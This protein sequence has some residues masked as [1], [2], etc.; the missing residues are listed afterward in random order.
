MLSKLTLVVERF[1][2][3]ES[4]QLRNLPDVM[5]TDGDSIRVGQ[6]DITLNGTKYIVSIGTEV[7]A[8]FDNKSIAVCFAKGYPA[9]VTGLSYFNM[10]DKRVTKS[11]QDAFRYSSIVRAN[12]AAKKYADADVFLD[13]LSEAQYVLNNTIYS[14]EQYNKRLL[15]TKY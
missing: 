14:A 11:K 10:L 2:A 12:I 1:I 8:S 4:Q 9:A 6:L 15:S 3:K 13:R 5:I 7:I